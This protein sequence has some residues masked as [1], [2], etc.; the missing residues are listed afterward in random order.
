MSYELGVIKSEVLDV[1]RSKVWQQ[2]FFNNQEVSY[3]SL[4]GTVLDN[5]LKSCLP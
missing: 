2:T 4:D 1:L 5:A 3:L